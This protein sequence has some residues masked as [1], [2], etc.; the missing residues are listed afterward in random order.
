MFALKNTDFTDVTLNGGFWKEKF[1]LVHD[2]TMQSVYDRFCETGR[3][4]AL[5]CDWVEGMPNKPHIFWDSD[6]AKWMEAAAYYT[7]LSRDEELEKKVDAAVDDIAAAQEESGYFNSFYL[8][9]DPEKRFTVRDNHELYCAGHL[10]EAA[11]AY[12]A[13]TK[14]RKFLDIM[15]KYI[16]YIYD[17]FVV[18]KSAAFVTPGHEE[19]ELALIKLYRYV[20]DKKYLELAAFFI[21]N[22]GIPSSDPETP[23]YSEGFGS[24]FAYNQSHIPVR[25]QYEA[26]GHAVRACYLYSAMADLA[27]ET[28]DAQL[29]TACD[30]LFEDITTRKMS[31]TGGIGANPIGEQFSYPFDL[32]NPNTYNETCAAI[33]LVFFAERMQRFD[34]DVRYAHT[35]E[36]ILYNGFLSG[37]SLSGDKFFYVNPLEI[38]P[39]KHDRIKHGLPITERVKVF[40]CSCCPPNIVRFIGSF[41]RLL[42]SQDGDTVY[43]NQF[44]DSKVNLTVGGKPA[45]LIQKTEYPLDGKIRFEYRG[46]PVTLKIRV[47]EWCVEYGGDTENG[48]AVYTLSDG[49]SVTVDFPMEIHFI[50]ASPDVQDN[51]GRYAVCRGPFVYCLEGTDN[52]ENL[53]DISIYENGKFEIG[54]DSKLSVPFISADACRRERIDSLYRIK[55]SSTVDFKA[56]LIPYYAFANRGTDEMLIWTMLK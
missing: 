10:L 45:L 29:K 24:A 44:A 4:D 20:G 13:A 35:V 40:S 7:H 12:D 32:P 8:S 47:P 37:I 50:E 25:E 6:V 36:R 53:R 19:I 22:R 14:K 27:A 1:D 5:R 16:D 54:F 46:E 51:S 56:K 30:R 52:G 15:I 18:R 55:T 26:V 41:G 23:P 39:K 2:V 17:V 43:C 11:I 34:S 33:S 48:Y 31:I 49:E 3:F 42:Y 21:N 38:D 28:D 9:T